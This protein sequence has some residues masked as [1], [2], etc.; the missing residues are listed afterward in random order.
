MMRVQGFCFVLAAL[1]LAMLP[2]RA[3]EPAEACLAKKMIAD[4]LLC[5]KD[6]ALEAGDAKL[7]LRSDQPAVRF[8]CVSLYA[9]QTRDPAVCAV[10]PVDEGTPPGTLRETCRAG[11]AVTM[12]DPELC[13]GFT[14]PNLAD[15]CF[16][17]M[18]MTGAD[19]ALCERIE[20]PTLK[21]A[22]GAK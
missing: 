6:A 20:N 10:I 12:N 11:L 8:N 1:V 13:A 18:V 4:Q 16:F 14:T 2:A 9:E 22:C 19:A 21:G 5:L 17:Q 3:A 15:A 7:C